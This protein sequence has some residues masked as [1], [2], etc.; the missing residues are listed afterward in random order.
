[1]EWENCLQ[2]RVLDVQFPRHKCTH[3]KPNV[4]VNGTITAAIFDCTG[5]PWSWFP[6]LQLRQASAAPHGSAQ[7][8]RRRAQAPGTRIQELER[9]AP[10]LAVPGLATPGTWDLTDQSLSWCPLHRQVDAYPLD[11]QRSP[12]VQFPRSATNSSPP[13][14]PAPTCRR[15]AASHPQS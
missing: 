5:S 1:M 3:V 14:P 7:A 9:V 13:T 15:S 2:K 12:T 10:Q 8:S 4:F 11:H 6:A